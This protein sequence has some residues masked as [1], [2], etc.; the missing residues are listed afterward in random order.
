MSAA[1]EE[2]TNPVKAPAPTPASPPP[3]VGSNSAWSA[4]VA[5]AKST[6]LTLDNRQ[7]EL[8]HKVS[9]YFSA[10]DTLQGNFVQTGADN[11]RMR[12]KFYVK[13][14]GRFRFDY[15]RPSRQI[16]VSDG[17]YLAIQDLDLN[18]EDR[19]S[20]D[21][22]PFRL[23]LRKDVDLVRDA[24]IMEV[25][26]SDD[27]LVVGLVDKSPDTPGQIKLLLSTKP[28]LELKEWVTKDA[29]GLD[30]RVQVSDLTKSGELDAELFKIKSIGRPMTMP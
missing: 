30:T 16:V 27:L 4:E 24:R 12:G 9:D 19:V 1:G 15:A 7:T 18:N 11:K 8:V 17:H 22:T 6:G 14:P 10:L 5:P 20:L 28:A 29:Q 2:A 21:D 13:R 25:Q 3:A 23:L 26:E